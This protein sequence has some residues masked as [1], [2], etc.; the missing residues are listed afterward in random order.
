M[1]GLKYLSHNQLDYNKWDTVVGSTTH[2][3]PYGFSWYLNWVSPGWEAIVYGN[4]EAV[5]PV[6]PQKKWMMRWTSRP[7][8][9]QQTGPYSKIP[10][11]EELVSEMIKLAMQKF[12]YG[13]FFLSN[14]TPMPRTWQPVA[15]VN[16]ELKLNR[17]YEELHHSYS[18]QIKRNLKKAS[19]VSYGWS[20]W[21]SI[22]ETLNLWK[23]NTQAKTKITDAQLA[24]LQLVLEFCYYNKRGTLMGIMDEGNNL[25]AAQFYIQHEGRATLI[26]NASSTWGK[27]HGLPSVLIDQFIRLHANSPVLLDFEGSSIAGLHRFYAG[28]GAQDQTYHMHV[29]NE[30]P[31]F[32]RRLKLDTTKK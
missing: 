19:K 8:G 1:H 32:L 7:F 13:E 28:F 9:T 26:L 23:Q 10:L 27:E 25:A 20:Q 14:G 30:L 18:S 4:Y 16:Q 15:L 11:T 12:H 2:P 17:R 21:P 5:L 22:S 29:V 6:F 31:V 3:Q 24:Q